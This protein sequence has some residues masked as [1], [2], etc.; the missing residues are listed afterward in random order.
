MDTHTLSPS[1]PPP[2]LSLSLSLFF[3]LCVHVCVCMRVRAFVFKGNV[4]CTDHHWRGPSAPARSAQILQ[5]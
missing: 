2:S 4:L 1:L 3:P 5:A